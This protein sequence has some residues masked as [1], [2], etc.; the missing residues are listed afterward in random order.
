[1]LLPAASKQGNG[2][3]SQQQLGPH[4]GGLV[5][6][7]QAVQLAQIGALAARCPGV[8]PS[9]QAAGADA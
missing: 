3:G 2:G 7:Q 1:M 4:H 6:A 5:A 8:G 9:K